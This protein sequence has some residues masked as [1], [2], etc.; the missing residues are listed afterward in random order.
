MATVPPIGKKR[1]PSVTAERVMELCERRLNSL[2]NPGICF[3]CG[4][5]ADGVEPDAREYVCE[6]CEQPRVYGCEEAL[7]M[8]V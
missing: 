2:D 8:M 4:E 7:L 5:E 6:S 3:A 1:H